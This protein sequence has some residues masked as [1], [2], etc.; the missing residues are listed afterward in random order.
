LHLVT[1]GCDLEHAMQ[2]KAMVRVGMV[3]MLMTLAGCHREVVTPV[4]VSRVTV[5]PGQA[6]V[7]Q[8]NRLQFTATVFDE[9]DRPLR[10]AEVVWSTGA[11]QVVSV[12]TGGTA[13]ALSPGSTLVRASFNGVSGSALVTVEPD[14][15]LPMAGSKKRDGGKGDDDDHD[16][17]DDDIDPRCSSPPD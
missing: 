6:S 3:G 13:R 7:P 8:G 17:A 2:G 16:G 12:E 15:S 10:Q 9:L 4:I 5:E 11:P 14:C 1:F